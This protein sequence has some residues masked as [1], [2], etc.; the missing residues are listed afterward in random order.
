M[1]LALFAAIMAYMPQP[2]SRAIEAMGPFLRPFLP[3]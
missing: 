3:D 1:P 2:I